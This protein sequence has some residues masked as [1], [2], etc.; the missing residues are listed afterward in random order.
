MLP[1]ARGA[2]FAPLI[3]LVGLLFGL[4]RAAADVSPPGPVVSA[5][6]LSDHLGEV[7]VIEVRDEALAEA[8]RF[9]TDPRT[10]ARRLVALGGR[11]PG[12][13]LVAFSDLREARVVDGVALRAMTPRRERFE[14]VMQEAGVEAGRT[15]V[16]VAPGDSAASLAM[17]THLYF[18]LRYFGQDRV[19]VLDG[20]LAGWLAAGHAY[21]T[22]TS[23]PGFG[24]WTATAEREEM[25][26]AAADVRRASRDGGAQ[27]ID[28]RPLAEFNG[29]VRNPIIAAAGHVAGARS[30]PLEGAAE[31]DGAAA[32]FLTPAAYR[33]RFAAHG[34]DSG[35]PAIAYCNSGLLASAVWFAL[36]EVMGEKG[37]RLY[38]GSM[39]EWTNLNN[40]VVG[41]SQ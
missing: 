36:S 11:L 30:F 5:Q 33:A 37:A 34:V 10:G 39:N 1:F 14:N 23:E 13:R 28:A 21:E 35:K 40:P 12:A 18:E 31:R 2:A 24:D 29:T 32:R 41:L 20:G 15:L 17:A 25:L 6:W 9:E 3:L 22:A 38:A 26:A 19:A 8:P 7:M 27:L 4:G 16:L